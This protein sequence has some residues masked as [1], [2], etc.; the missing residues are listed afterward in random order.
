MKKILYFALSLMILTMVGLS[1]CDEPAVPDDTDPRANYTYTWTCQELGG[2]TYSVVITEDPANSTQ[3]LMGN[4]HM[5]GVNEKAY[6]IAT[7]N[8]LTIPSQELC[9]NTINGS[10]TLTNANKITLKYYVN[11]HSTI[12][13]INATYTK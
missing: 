6:A 7:A 1:S 3:V 5:L 13:T 4:F 11:N 10:G 9:N 2:L 12:D 8:N